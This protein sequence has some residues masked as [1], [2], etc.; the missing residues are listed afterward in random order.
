MSQN[1]AISFDLGTSSLKGIIMDSQANIISY[2][3]RTV[4][5]TYMKEDWVESEPKAWWNAACEISKS[6]IHQSGIN[7]EKVCGISFD[8]PACGLIPMNKDKGCLYPSIIWLD[9]R[10]EGVA[11]ELND[12]IA[13]ATADKDNRP[14]TGKDEIPKILWLKRNRP[15]LWNEMDCFVDDTGYMVY[16]ATKELICSIQCAVSISYDDKTKNW[17]WLYTDSYGIERNKFPKMVQATDV[18][19]GLT[20]Q[21][22]KELGLPAGIPVSAGL[23]DCNAAEIGLGCTIPGD[24]A[25]YI[26]T[27]MLFTIVTEKYGMSSHAAYAFKSCNP[28]YSMFLLT[29]DMSGGCIDWIVDRLF[30]PDELNLSM[31]ECYAKVDKL[32]DETSPGANNLYFSTWFCGERQPV[33]DN[34]IRAGFWNMNAD[35]NRGHMVR[36]VYEGIAYEIR[37]TLKELEKKHGLSYKRLR[38]AGGGAKSN[39]LMQIIADITDITIDVIEDASLA[40]AKGSAYLALITAGILTFEEVRDIVKVESTFI[41]RPEYKTI[42]DRGIHYYQKYYEVSKDYYKELNKQA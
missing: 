41:P 4:T 21:A 25:M 34:Y 31:N 29:N 5:P 22:A 17:N 16:R 13:A 18:V 38:V 35:H 7:P 30:S 36:A 8:A 32:L 10:A 33:C 1:Y 26:G 11:S 24:A 40:V 2:D 19:G 20:E 39:R 6:M 27:S 9:S 37:W 28:K 15:D 23:S 14:F 3:S 42:Y 12:Q